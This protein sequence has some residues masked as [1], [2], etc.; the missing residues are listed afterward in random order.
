MVRRLPE[1]RVLLVAA[2]VALF[3]LAVILLVLVRAKTPTPAPTTTSVT[4]DRDA[5]PTVPKVSA[6][7]PSPDAAP[8]RHAADA[9]VIAGAE[10]ARRQREE[11]MATMRASGAAEE[12]WDAQAK[13]FFATVATGPVTASDVGCYIAGCAATFTFPS[14]DSFYARTAE[15]RSTPAYDAWTGGKLLTPPEILP[16]GRVRASWILYRPD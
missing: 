13:A 14:E 15:A 1:R 11:K 9:A 12:T 4:G 7:S 3:A 8:M 5:G 16:D 2:A 6:R 10:D